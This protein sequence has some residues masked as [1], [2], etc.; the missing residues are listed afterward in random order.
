[1]A[2]GSADPACG[3]PVGLRGWVEAGSC[4]GSLTG[5]P[6]PSAGRCVWP[7]A[8]QC[9]LLWLRRRWCNDVTPAGAVLGWRALHV[10]GR[11]RGGRPSDGCGE[12]VPCGGCMFPVMHGAQENV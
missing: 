11:L 10:R 1:M 8:Y 2:H 7:H 9:A 4:G 3:T 5:N 6:E 12:T